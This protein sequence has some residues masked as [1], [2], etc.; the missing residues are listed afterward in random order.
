MF[1]KKG[2]NFLTV[3]SKKFTLPKMQFFDTMT[4]E[5]WNSAT[6]CPV[7]TPGYAQP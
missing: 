5:V 2:V 1:F 7:M 6:A 4:V 3:F